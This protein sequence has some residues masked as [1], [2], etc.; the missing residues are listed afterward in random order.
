[1]TFLE[2][3]PTSVEVAG[4]TYFIYTDFRDWIRFDRLLRDDTISDQERA[5]LMLDWFID[6]L[7]PPV[8]EIFQALFRFFLCGKE[9]EK[10]GRNQKLVFDFEQDM[11]MVYSGFV[12]SYQVNLVQVEYLHWWEFRALLD[13]LPEDTRMSQIM[14][15][16]AVDISKLP[17]SEQN[18]YREL[19]RLYAIGVSG[20][21]P[22]SL[23]QRNKE[24]MERARQARERAMGKVP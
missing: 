3:L 22:Q 24:L 18:R 11:P 15:Y 5:A 7:P 21:L 9:P 4:G 20:K 1:M 23:E 10:P 19:Q 2:E 12:Q 14:G 16:R 13:G 6:E 8:P 17:K